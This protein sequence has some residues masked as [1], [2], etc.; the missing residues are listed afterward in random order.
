VRTRPFEWFGRLGINAKL[1]SLCLLLAT[2]PVLLAGTFVIT[3]IARSAESQARAQLDEKLGRAELIL[4]A[5]REEVERGAAALSRDNLITINLDLGLEGP[6]RGYLKER[7]TALAL[8]F[9]GV[10][11]PE[12]GVWLDSDES[13]L[14]EEVAALLGPGR[15]EAAQA[16]GN[17]PFALPGPGKG[18]ISGCVSRIVAD[19]G[20]VLGYLVAGDYLAPDSTLLKSLSAQLGALLKVVPGGS[21]E[22]GY[23]K[24]IIG[25][26]PWLFEY[27][28]LWGP[29]HAGSLAVGI[30]KNDYLSG[31]NQTILAFVAIFLGAGLVSAVLGIFFSRSIVNR[32]QALVTGTERIAGG[33]F[34]ESI[35]VVQEDELGALARSFNSMAGRLG[36]SLRE[37]KALNEGLESRIAERTEELSATNEELGATID[38]LEATMAQLVESEKMASLGQLVASIAHELNTPLGAISSANEGMDV[39]LRDVLVRLPVLRAELQGPEAAAFDNI[40]AKAL[41]NRPLRSRTSADRAVGR[42]LERKLREAGITDPEDM[43]ENLSEIGIADPD[44]ALVALLAGA[45]GRRMIE[46]AASVAWLIRAREIIDSASGKA[47][48]TIL[49]LKTYSHLD[50]VDE[51]VEFDVRKELDT[52]LDLY[53]GMTKRGV[54]V[55]RNYAEVPKLKGRRDNLNQV[56]INLINNALQAMEYRGVLGIAV[57]PVE[58]GIEVAVSDSGPGVAP[59]IRDRIFDAFFTTKRQGEG[60]GLGLSI[61]QK[62]VEAHQGSIRFES[63]PGKTV[64]VVTLPLEKTGPAQ[65]NQ[66]PTV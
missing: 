26:D 36:A 43:V 56:W 40:L 42:A 4:S 47:A 15:R 24:A 20:E 7:R 38:N 37:L 21:E 46:L 16:E 66:D 22:S 64:F 58:G 23:S 55:L 39:Q 27:T 51:N 12:G 28:G 57:A 30:R 48:R 34:D 41:E 6:V 50:P 54:E 19:Q 65:A 17:R 11:D 1:L 63:L 49:A 60:A 14:F 25:G 61:C 10:L 31:R 52:I 62:I 3:F 18:I 2:V 35:P 32:V 44:D 45:K 53:Y 13:G 8:D 5:R 59:E 9:L 33:N 29:E